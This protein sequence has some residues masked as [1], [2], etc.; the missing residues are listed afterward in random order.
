MVLMVTMAKHGL[1]LSQV[2]KAT[3]SDSYSSTKVF[4]LGSLIILEACPLVLYL[5][6]PV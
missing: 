1:H 6:S 5:H 2:I 4:S 3:V